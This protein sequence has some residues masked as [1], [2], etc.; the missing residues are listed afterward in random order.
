MAF[1]PRDR[2]TVPEALEHPWLAQ[3]HDV[4]DEPDCPVPYEAWRDIEKLT[5]ID[6]FREALWNEIE[7][8]RH[9]VRRAVFDFSVPSWSVPSK[10]PSGGTSSIRTDQYL[11]TLDEGLPGIVVGGAS[12]D[13]APTAVEEPSTTDEALIDEGHKVKHEAEAT[14]I[15]DATLVHTP[16]EM[17][18]LRPGVERKDSMRPPDMIYDPVVSY[19][20]RSSILHAQH[21]QQQFDLQH[22]ASS[23]VS[24]TRRLSG[25][26]P[27][28]Q[29]FDYIPGITYYAPGVVSQLRDGMPTPPPMMASSISSGASSTAGATGMVPFPSTGGSYIV[30]ARSRTAS[31]VGGEGYFPGGSFIGARKL[32]R[33]LSTVSIHESAEGLAGGLAAMGPIGQAIIDRETAADAPPSEMP[34]DFGTVKEEEEQKTGGDGSGSSSARSVREKAKNGGRR[35]G[36]ASGNGSA[37]GTPSASGLPTTKRK[38]RRFIL[39]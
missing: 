11:E 5:T 6:E 13:T 22:T 16:S 3:Y 8:Y 12:T 1:D 35:S 4:G 27:H 17:P 37:S 34:R 15:A 36:T 30:P 38:E 26:P 19:A 24:P 7:E 31:T 21:A 29:D 9:E 14:I 18:H 33:T 20:R 23:S 25:I 28:Y 32:L 10:L 2:I 39:F